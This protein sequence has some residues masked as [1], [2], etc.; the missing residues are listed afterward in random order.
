[1]RKR[2]ENILLVIITFL[3]IPIT[4]ITVI[5]ALIVLVDVWSVKVLNDFISETKKE[6]E[7]E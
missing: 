6:T 5:T 3:H 1:M 2:A 4:I 7:N